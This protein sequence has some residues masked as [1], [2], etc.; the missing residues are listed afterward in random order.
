V[1][2]HNKKRNV[3]LIYELL[4]Q[5]LSRAVVEND[6][7]KIAT[8]QE[9]IK[10]RFKKGTELYKEF[11]LFNALVATSGVSEQLAY[12]I[13]NEAKAASSD[14]NHKLLDKE[15]SLL[16]RDVNHKLNETNF[17]NVKV[18]NYPVYASAQQLFNGWR[19]DDISITEIAKHEA[20]VH[21][22]LIRD[23]NNDNLEEHTTPQVNDLTFHIMQE[24]FEQKY[25]TSLSKEQTSILKLYCEGDNKGLSKTATEISKQLSR[26][27]NKYEKKSRDNFLVEKIQRVNSSVDGYVFSSDIDDV[28][29]MMTLA[30][31]L[32]EIREITNVNN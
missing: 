10:N 12:R 9:I 27:I 20:T 6:A 2:R 29:K 1:A 14:H 19:G 26:Q 11:R 13:L 32:S 15:K 7:K 28:S 21:S 8:V 4:I 17:Y 24:K 5:R 31:L 3:G 18:K 25:G 22:W 23:E 16:I 30:Q